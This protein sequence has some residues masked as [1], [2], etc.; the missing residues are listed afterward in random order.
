MMHADLT[1]ITLTRNS[2]KYLRQCLH[3]F[4]SSFAH[5]TSPERIRHIVVDSYS[6]DSTLEILKS[7]SRTEV[8]S[9]PHNGIYQSLNYSVSLTDSKYVSFLHSDD[10]CD[11][12]F[13]PS[14]LEL[15]DLTVNLTSLPIYYGKVV[16]IDEKSRVLFERRAPTLLKFIQS[17]KNLILHPNCLFPRD[18]EVLFPY[19]ETLGLSADHEHINKLLHHASFIRSSIL[20]YRFRISPSSSTVD[21]IRSGYHDS[22]SFSSLCVFFCS[23]YL[24]FESSRFKRL[25]RRLY[26]RKGSWR[27]Y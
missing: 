8:F 16:F 9:C 18:F 17:R 12:S 27:D 19:S 2:A 26:K 20:T 13:L 23:L 3:S 10:E 5:V 25:V 6:S 15:I 7:F 11:V 21:T 24:F 14:A 4:Y 1:V 22:W